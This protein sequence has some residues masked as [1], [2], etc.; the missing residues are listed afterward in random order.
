[1]YGNGYFKTLEDLYPV[2]S[3]GILAIYLFTLLL[4]VALRYHLEVGDCSLSS[5]TSPLDPQSKR[6]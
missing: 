1:M 3:V 5:E 6:L 2:R 4:M